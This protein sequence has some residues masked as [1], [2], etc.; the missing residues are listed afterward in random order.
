MHFSSVFSQLGRSWKI[1]EDPRS[2]WE[3][4]EDPRRSWKTLEDLEDLGRSWKILDPG[5]RPEDR[6]ARPRG[7]SVHSSAKR[8]PTASVS[9]HSSRT[10]SHRQR[11]HSHAL[12]RSGT[13]LAAPSASLPRHKAAGAALDSVQAISQEHRPV[14]TSVECCQLLCVDSCVP[15][16]C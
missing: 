6:S 5:A 14:D 9:F 16:G 13:P 10:T 15:Q 11:G 4:L 12:C 7:L 2:F 1:L 8:G 3:I